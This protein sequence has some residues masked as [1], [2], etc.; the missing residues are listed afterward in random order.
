LKSSLPFGVTDRILN[1][2]DFVLVLVQMMELKIWCKSD[3]EGKLYKYIDNKWKLVPL[4]ERFQLTKIEGQIWISLYELLLNP[5]CVSKYDYTDYKKNQILKLRSQMNEVLVDQ[6]P[7][8]GALQR[9]L[10][11]LAIS[12]PPAYKSSLIIE[13]V[14]EIFENMM[15]NNKG[16]WKKLAKEQASTVL[17]PDDKAIKEQAKR[18]LSLVWLFHYHIL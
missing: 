1:K 11:Q 6:I 12:E 10:E 14:S 18:L 3:K 2:H 8:L 16:K 9:F 7:N 15:A 13:Q 17:S 5:Q 4:S